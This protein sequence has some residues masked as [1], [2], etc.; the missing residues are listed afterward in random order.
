MILQDLTLGPRMRF[1]S[2]R[3]VRNPSGLFVTGERTPL[4]DL[5][6]ALFFGGII[7]KSYATQETTSPKTLIVKIQGLTPGLIIFT[8]ILASA[9][10]LS[11][12]KKKDDFWLPMEERVKMGY[13]PELILKFKELT[14]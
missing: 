12:D 6:V 10:V 1:L 9:Y 7:Y 3:L 4:S 14:L 13:V 5:V 11:A 8:L 2:L